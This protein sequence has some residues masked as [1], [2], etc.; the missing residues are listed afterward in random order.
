MAKSKDKKPS[1]KK[2]SAKSVVKAAT[3]VAP[4]KNL[5]EKGE[6]AVK[7]A[8]KGVGDAWEKGQTARKGIWK[9]VARPGKG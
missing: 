5:L 4:Q 7:G 8:I 3:K 1:P 2:P 6:D 9:D